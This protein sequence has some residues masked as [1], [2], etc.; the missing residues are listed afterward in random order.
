MPDP[1]LELVQATRALM[2]AAATTDVADA[3][4]DEARLLVERAA[5]LLSSATRPTLRRDHLDRDAIARTRAGEPWP[6]FAHN[7]QAVFQ[8][9]LVAEGEARSTV[10]P[11]PLLEGPPGLMHGGYSAHLLDAL[12]S[13]LVQTQDLRA[14]TASLTVRYL[15]PV[16]LDVPLEVSGRLTGRDGRKIHA[17]GWIT[18]AGEQV[19][20]ATALMIEIPGEPD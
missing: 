1:A 5:A 16:P 9:V 11:S 13:T 15:K 8:T 10:V 14:V 18:R 2:L 4:Q 3:D 6:V 20:A 7:P 19:V 17:E 12:L